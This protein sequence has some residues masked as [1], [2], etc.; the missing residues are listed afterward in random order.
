MSEP[1]ILES[2]RSAQAQPRSFISIQY[3]RGFAALAVVAFHTSWTHSQLGQ[4]GVDLFFVIS[5]FIM[6]LS[7][8]GRQRRS[9]SC[10]PASS[11]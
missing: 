8:S 7:A 2:G 5:G 4:A 3:L 11:G 6:V 10:E 1:A 9:S